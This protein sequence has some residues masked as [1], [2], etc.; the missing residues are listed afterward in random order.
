MKVIES[1]ARTNQELILATDGP[2]LAVIL[3]DTAATDR[4]MFYAN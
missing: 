3:S 4:F 2:S 1:Q